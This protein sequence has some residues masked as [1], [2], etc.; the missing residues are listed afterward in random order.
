MSKSRKR[1]ANRR[2]VRVVSSGMPVVPLQ[3]FVTTSLSELPRGKSN[4]SCWA[5]T[6]T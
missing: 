1:T 4:S 6:I 2:R 3:R 5:P